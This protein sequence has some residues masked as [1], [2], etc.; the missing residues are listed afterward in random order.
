MTRFLPSRSTRVLAALAVVCGTAGVASVVG[1]TSSAQADPSWVSS[2]SGVGAD[3]SQDLYAALTGTSP[4]NS[5]ASQFFTPLHSSSATSNRTISSFDANPA[6]GST[7]LPGA[8]TTK[9]G[10]PAFDRPN[11]TTAGLAAL[12]AAATGSGWEASSNSATNAP[13]NVTGQIDFARA[14]RGPKLSGT[15]LTFIPFGRD[16]VGVAYFDHSTGH[17]ATLTTA[18]LNSLYSSSTGTTTIGGDTVYACLTLSGSTP[19]SN[20]ETAI[21]VSDATANTAANAAGCNGIEQNNANAFYTFASG[22]PS[23]SDAVIPISSASWIGQAN[24][25]GVDRSSTARAG[26]VDLASIDSL[27][28]PYTGTDATTEVPSPT[29]YASTSYGYNVYSVAPS[30]KVTGAFGDA[31]LKSLFVGS[32]SALCSAPAQATVNQFGF[33]SFTGAL[34]GLGVCGTTT[35][36]GNG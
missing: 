1:L 34:S 24:T 8:I 3:V 15:T 27:G 12:L 23:G 35:Q 33:A 28:K 9:L 7:T 11:S 19:R 25:V 4:A 31:G 29:Y 22:L 30:N 13:V 32:T 10:G 17:L 6:G 16:A 20:L 26:G 14:A 21:G 18:Q 36:Q 2:Y 5:S